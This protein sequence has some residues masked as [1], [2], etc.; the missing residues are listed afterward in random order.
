MR[1]WEVAFKLAEP[2]SGGAMFKSK[3]T[4]LGV[5]VFNTTL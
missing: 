1:K 2:E 5:Q 4:G 3:Q